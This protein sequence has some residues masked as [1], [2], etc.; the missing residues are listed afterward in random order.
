[1]NDETFG[2][3]EEAKILLRKA[4]KHGIVSRVNRLLSK[5]NKRLNELSVLR[6][7]YRNFYLTLVYKHMEQVIKENDWPGEN[8]ESFFLNVA[9][10]KF[11]NAINHNP[12]KQS[13]KE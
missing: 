3:S 4:E 1:M 12:Y 2:S 9:N 6:L 11:A 5:Y 13:R 10:I 7:E 8:T